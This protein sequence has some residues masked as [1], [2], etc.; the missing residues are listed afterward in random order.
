M[1]SSK[2]MLEALKEKIDNGDIKNSAEHKDD[3]ILLA[4][5]LPQFTRG[6]YRLNFG[7]R[8]RTASI[9]NFQLC[10]TDSVHLNTSL[11]SKIPNDVILQMGKYS[12]DKFH[13]DF[14]YPMTA[15]QALGV[16]LSQFA[17]KS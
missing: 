13:V 11:D 16:C 1:I 9:K 14:K 5:K 15:F 10:S 12:K 4:N 8:V 17:K 3:F 7:G 2:P 6:S